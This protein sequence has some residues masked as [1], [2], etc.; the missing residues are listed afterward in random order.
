M[1]LFISSFFESAYCQDSDFFSLALLKE[2]GW[3]YFGASYVQLAV[4]GSYK[5][6]PILIAS[7]DSWVVVSFPLC[8]EE[9]IF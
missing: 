4:L 9:P 8:E 2:E 5:L 7:T 6:C 1:L 3:Y